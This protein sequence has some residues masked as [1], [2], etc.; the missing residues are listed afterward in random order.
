MFD[1]EAFG[2]EIVG[3][4]RG[5]LE[6]EVAPVLER[7]EA[8]EKRLSELPA[9]KDGADGKDAD[10]EEVADIV[11]NRLASEIDELREIVTAP[12][13]SDD[14][15]KGMIAEAVETIPQPKDGADG[16]DADMA[17][18]K[19]MIDEVVAAL[20]APEKGE[21]GEKGEKGDPGSDG[22]DG[23][24]GADGLNGKDG[25]DGLDV[26]E[27]F[28]ADGG[29]LVA[30]MTDGTTRDLG[31]YVGKDGEPGKPGADGKDGADGV[32]FDEMDLV[33]T[34]QGVML[35]FVRDEV[36]KDWRVPIVR[37]CGVYKAG[38]TYRKGDGVTWAG[39][40]WIAQEETTEKPDTGKGWRLAVKKGR[41]GKSEKAK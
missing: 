37:D 18:V 34:E 7:I 41:D 36:T 17:E 39:S 38:T 31:V 19:A 13:M 3:I 8:V 27:M 30:V 40:F 16:K 35:R 21:P 29:R 10:P 33:E 1:G 32:G 23:K 22:K 28:R 12:R 26:K 11:S 2:K 25:R 15:I 24:D 9:P 14:E 4:V 6:K 5:Y 20:P